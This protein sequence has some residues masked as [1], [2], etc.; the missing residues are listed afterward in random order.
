MT[1]LHN[2]ALARV[3]TLEAR[4]E[5]L[6][7]VQEL[8]LRLLSTTRP[9]AGVLEHYSATET[10]EQA[11]YR[12]LDTMAGRIAGAERDRPSFAFFEMQ[13][14]EIF[15]DLRGDREFVQLLIDTLRVE[16]PAYRTLHGYM[17]AHHW[18]SWS[19]T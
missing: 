18:P 19:A 10:Q 8:L 7:A 11:F 13:V 3:A 15:P 5:A 4:V 17:V 2:D 9:L 6:E 1:D 12:L 16:R 14:N